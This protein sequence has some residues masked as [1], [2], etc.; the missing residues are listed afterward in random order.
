MVAIAALQ[1]T[2][3]MLFDLTAWKGGGFGMFASFDHGS[4]RFVR[5]YALG[6]TGRVRIRNVR[7][8]RKLE[9]AFAMVP[10]ERTARAMATHLSEMDRPLGFDRVSVELWST[11]LVEGHLTASLVT[12]FLFP[13]PLGD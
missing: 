12:Q 13:I 7:E 11:S 2:S 3:A 4:A 1:M 5:Y 6:E 10:S 8:L 9:Q